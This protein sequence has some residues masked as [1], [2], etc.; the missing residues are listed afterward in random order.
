MVTRYF[1]LR[2][3]TVCGLDAY[4]PLIP[5]PPSGRRLLLFA[6]ETDTLFFLFKIS[7]TGNFFRPRTE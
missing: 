1:A 7:R 6:A 4:F 3:M 5:N 2:I